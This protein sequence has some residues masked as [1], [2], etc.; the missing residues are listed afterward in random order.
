MTY[1]KYICEG[2]LGQSTKKTSTVQHILKYYTIIQ[3]YITRK[4]THT[5]TPQKVQDP[6]AQSCMH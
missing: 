1:I 3:T 6:S 4:C 5:G 2:T